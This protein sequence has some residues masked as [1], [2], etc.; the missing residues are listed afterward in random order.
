MNVDKSQHRI[1]KMFGEISGQYDFLNHLLS[2]GTDYYWRWR[3]VRTVSPNGNDPILDV[4]CGTGDLAIAYWKKGN[5]RT[6]VV[7]TDFTHEML[8]LA[9]K[10]TSK[11]AITSSAEQAD[12]AISFL[13]ADTQQLPFADDRFQIVSVGFGLRNVTDTERGLREMVRVCR[14][15]GF[16][17]VLEFSMPGNRILRGLY[18]WYFK[19]IL[20]RIGQLFARNRESAYN[21]LPQSVSEFPQDEELAEIMRHCGLEPVRWKPLTFGI[22]T[23]YWGEKPGSAC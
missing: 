14:P 1:R 17:V 22:A 12:Q 10:K 6:Q 8:K 16:V 15:G 20:P 4:C 18:R 9:N 19:H 23:L 13:E 21:Y 2:G 3:T 7:G 11:F 5:R